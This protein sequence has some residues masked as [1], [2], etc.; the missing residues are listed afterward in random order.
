VSTKVQETRLLIR[1]AGEISDRWL[2]QVLDVDNLTVISVERIGTG[3]MSQS[4]RV[5]FGTPAGSGSVVVKLASEDATSRATGVDMGAYAREVAFYRNA[6]NR[7]GP[8]P[9]CYLAVYDKAGGWFTLVLSDIV[10]AVVGDQIRGCSDLQARLGIRA[11]AELHAPMFNDAAE[12]R[13]GYA[14]QRNPLNQSL[15][16]VLLP[17][18]L[19]RY[20]D[21]IAADHAQVCRTFVA[22]LD[23]WAADRRAPFGLV[24]GDYRLDNLL[25]GADSCT[26]VDWQTVS[27]GPVMTDVAY[28]LG[29]SLVVAD[30]R[31]QERELVRF[32]HDE[33]VRRGVGNFTWEQCWAGYRRQ[34]FAC[35][36]VTVAAGVVVERTDR[37]DDM[38]MAVLARVC[39]QILDLDAL[40]LL[41]PQARPAALRPEPSDEGRHSPGPEPLWNESWYFD[42][43]DATGSLGVYVRMGLHP[44]D[45]RCFYAASIVRPGHPTLM[46]VDEAAPL[47]ED[48]GPVEKV[49]TKALRGIQDCIEP[50]RRIHVT[51]DATAQAFT[52]HSAPLR[53][54]TGDPLAVS[55]DLTWD[56][57]GTPYAWRAATRYEIPCRVTGVIRIGEQDFNFT[58]PG[59]RDHSWGSRDWWAHDWMWSAFHL[60]D[61]TRTHVVTVP[62]MPGG[63]AIGYVQRGDSLTEVQTGTS[64]ETIDP[65]G[66]I[67]AAQVVTGP[68]ELLLDVEPVGFGA[69]RLVATDGRITH[70]PRAMARVQTADGRTGIGWIEWNINQPLPSHQV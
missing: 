5:R 59:Q 44:N 39:Q 33:L 20:A 19:D 37:G 23:G 45:G 27:W 49:E 22:A 28:F 32:Y 30:R 12:G 66:L 9:A 68:D 11:L 50:L 61:G 54:E 70:F 58:G 16:S 57:D 36:I 25:F 47:P 10:A 56:T 26:V 38:L 51:L 46:V 29:S 40:D 24:H 7:N 18:F 63:M 43:V 2:G 55:L 69:L 31:A 67:S 13:R 17:T 1:D 41:P 8:L 6:S 35:L 64:T 42:A 52:D 4:H 62:N 21:R 65:D 48:N 14:N 34:T 60:S 15:M 53:G 3:Q